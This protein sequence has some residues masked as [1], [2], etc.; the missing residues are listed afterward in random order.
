MRRSNRLLYGF[1][2]SLGAALLLCSYI[3][4]SKFPLFADVI[5]DFGVV[6]ISLVL[7]HLLWNIVGGDP[8]SEEISQLKKLNLLNQDSDIS[9]LT[10]L[11]VKATDITHDKWL[12]LIQNSRVQ[13]DICA[14]TLYDITDRVDLLNALVE[15]I[16]A[17]IKVRLLLNSSDNPVWIYGVDYS[18]PNLETMKQQMEYS[19]TK[20]NQLRESLP[21]SIKSN[22]SLVKLNKEQMHVALRRFDDQMFIVHYVYSARTSETPVYV[23]EGSDKPL[24]RFYIYE[25]EHL[26]E[27]NSNKMGQ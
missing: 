8:L 10:R 5:K 25:F 2:I 13:I 24:F 22:L 7:I 21:V 6:V 9:G 26:F 18:H 15:R 19:W 3:L 11:H 17:G 14:N 12:K 27:H 23:I 20:L 1:F 4:N 16:N